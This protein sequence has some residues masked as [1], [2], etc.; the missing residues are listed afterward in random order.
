MPPRRI[1]FHGIDPAVPVDRRQRRLP[2]WEQPGVTYFV[3]FRLAD[4]VPLSLLAQWE[5]E[6]AIWRRCHPAPWSE[7]DEREYRERFTERM[8]AWLDAG[9]GACHLRNGEVRRS[10]ETVLLEFDAVRYDVDA[11]V[12][13]PNHVHLLIV[14]CSGRTLRAVMK[15][16]K[17]V[18]AKRSNGLLVRSGTFWMDESYDHIV[19]D[20]GELAAFRRYIEENPRKVGLR[21]D[22][23]SLSMREVLQVT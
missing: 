9:M 12:L 23:Y 5:E 3:T 18:S 22:E 13:M 8:E 21:T 6:R 16:I 17:G 1:P 19:R 10:V 20:A 4:S 14:P 11:F 15:G 7:S 2:H